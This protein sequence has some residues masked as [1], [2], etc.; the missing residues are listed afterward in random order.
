MT[1]LKI[2]KY[3]FQFNLLIDTIVYDIPQNKEI[4]IIVYNILSY[5]IYFAL[6]KIL[7]V[8]NLLVFMIIFFFCIIDEK[9]PDFDSEKTLEEHTLKNKDVSTEKEKK[10]PP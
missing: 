4:F 5:R 7:K 1:Y 9:N 10:N 3:L 6:P 8:V 2:K